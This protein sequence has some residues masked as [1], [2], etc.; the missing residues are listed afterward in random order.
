MRKLILFFCFLSS[1]FA[2]SL[3]LDVVVD[4]SLFANNTEYALNFQFNPGG[5]PPVDPA[6][7]TVSNFSLTGGTLGAEVIK[8]GNAGLTDL[9]SSVTLDNGTPFNDYLHRIATLGT[10]ISFR[11]SLSV[12]TVSGTAGSGSTFS[13][14]LFQGD[15][16]VPFSD[17]LYIV[18]APFTSSLASGQLFEVSVSE[19]GAF[20]QSNGNTDLITLT[21]V[22]PPPP[23]GG[24]IPE[25]STALLLA[26]SLPVFAALRRR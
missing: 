19:T 7:A 13:F 24:E 21:V 5:T 10:A 23:I 2:A 17:P 8:T 22:P 25:P 11:L 9:P 15:G 6:T 20:T 12:P 14:G 1:S 3:T 26:L 4:T 16:N 18:G